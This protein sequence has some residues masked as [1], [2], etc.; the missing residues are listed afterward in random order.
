MA[1]EESWRWFKTVFLKVE[2]RGLGP[3]CSRTSF[4]N[5]LVKHSTDKTSETPPCRLC[6]DSTEKVWHIVSGCRKLV[7]SEYRKRHDKV[8]LRVHWELCRKYGLE[9]TD[10]WYDHQPLPVAENNGNE[11]NLRCDFL[12]RRAAEADRPDITLVHK[13]TQQ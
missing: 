8:A 9:C 1:G 6:G 11:D 4:E 7:Q 13:D 12:Y 2:N 5:K 3:R 10:R